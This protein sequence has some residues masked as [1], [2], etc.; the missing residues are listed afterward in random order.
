M[1]LAP[2]SVGRRLGACISVMGRADVTSMRGYETLGI[3]TYVAKSSFAFSRVLYL[4]GGIDSWSLKK[5]GLHEFKVLT[6]VNI[7]T[8]QYNPVP[9]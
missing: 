3:A 8:T 7:N 6:A 9:R 4:P 1:P 2:V 5:F